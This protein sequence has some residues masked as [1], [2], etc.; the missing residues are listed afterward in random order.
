MTIGNPTELEERLATLEKE[1]TREST[2]H[3]KTSPRLIVASVAIILVVIVA[4]IA[5][6]WSAHSGQNPL[7]V[8]IVSQ[9]DFPVYYPNPLPKDVTYKSKSARTEADVFFY[10]LVSRG[11]EITVS[12]QRV[13]DAPPAIANL[14]GFKKIDSALGTTVI[15]TNAGKPV[16]LLLTNTTLVTLSAPRDLPSDVLIGIAQ[17]MRTAP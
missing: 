16:L 11:K 7:P 10:T 14:I 15:G 4:G 12:E 5:W 17:S 3:R 6:K 9:A 2:P 13:P 1:L 8:A